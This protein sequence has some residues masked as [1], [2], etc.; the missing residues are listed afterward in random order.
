VEAVGLGYLRLGQPLVTLSGGEAQ[1]LKLARALVSAKEGTLL[2]LDEPTVGLHPG[3]VETL[4]EALEQLVERG[5]SVVVVEHDMTVAA[6][7]DWVIDLDPGAGDDG[8]TVVAAGPPAK[9]ASSKSRT[10]PFLAAALAGRPEVSPEA[11]AEPRAS[12][13]SGAGDEVVVRGAREHNLTDLD[14]D[15]P[16]S[17]LT[18]VT[19]PS[20]SGKSTLAF[21]V[22]HAEG[23]RRYLESL[24]TFVRQYL[25]QL[26]RPEVDRVDGVPPSVALEPRS[27]RSGGSTVGTLTE[28]SHYLRLL[29][30]RVGTQHCPD[31][32]VP[33]QAR[34]RT[35]IHADVRKTVGRRGTASLLARVVQNRKGT[36]KDLIVRAARRGIDRVRVDGVMHPTD[37]PP[38]LDRYSEHDVDLEVAVVRGGA[39][40]EAALDEALSVGKGAVRVL[41]GEQETVLSLTRTCPDCGR[42]FGELDPTMFSFHTRKGAC[43]DCE[44]AGTAV[45]LDEDAVFQ[46]GTPLGEGGLRLL[47]VK[48]TRAKL[49]RRLTRAGVPLDRTLAKLTA[50]QRRVLLDGKRPWSGLLEET[51]ALAD[52]GEHEAIDMLRDVACPSCD[53][54]RLSE[55]PSHVVLSGEGT[56]GLTLPALLALP[57]SWALDWLS[58]LD[59]PDRLKA[60]GE[61]LRVE[62]ARRLAFL[63]DTGVGYLTLGRP[64]ETLS[65][66][67]TQRVRLAAQLGSGLTGV[68]Y[69]LDEPTIGL[70][71]RD[72]GQLLGTL[73]RLAEQGCM[74]LVVEHDEQ[75]IR[76]ADHV[77]DL[78]PGGGSRGGRIVAR[79]TP[80]EICASDDS[81]TGRALS[82]AVP[83]APERRDLEGV[84]WLEV[85]G[86]AGHNL[87][88]IDVSFPVERLTVV[89]GVSGSG[90]S[91]LVREILWRGVRR[92]LGLIASRPGEHQGIDGVDHLRRAVEVDQSPI[93]RTPR[94]VPATYIKIWDD[95]RK[96]LARTP[97]ARARGF[98]PERFSFNRKGGRC[99][100]CAGQGAT[101]VEMSF[102]PNVTAKCEACG[103]TRFDRATREVTYRGL[104]VDQILALTAEEAKTVFEAFPRVRRAL[105]LLDDL[106]LGYLALGQ[107]SNT[108]SGGEAQRIKLAAELH[109]R[110]RGGT[111]Y[112]LDEPT[113]GL[114]LSDVGRLVAVLQRLV[115][116]GDTVVVIEHHPDVIWAADYVAD[117]GPEG[118]DEGGGLVV[119]GPPE[120][121]VAHETSYTGAALRDLLEKRTA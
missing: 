3:D 82:R 43:P 80:D 29:Y 51:W 66:G 67:E 72:T 118:G 11:L 63:Q 73:G 83:A 104:S 116:R 74:V 20:G 78:G 34:T 79:G 42:G 46:Q 92:Q 95:I 45:A 85:R 71:P 26:P 54:S 47:E 121:V 41:R 107:P 75:T 55:E 98:G 120:L 119:S 48:R 101:K 32:A 18:V 19:G 58:S 70:H 106:G 52:E 13:G 38:E 37:P 22:V 110:K 30:A 17:G 87:R 64:A 8:G 21:D 35:Q 61:P 5:C 62:A 113:T 100:E 117:L 2:V 97:D 50:A 28:V 31:C 68:A 40:L 93:G 7:A 59:L 44:G 94:S 91:T 102:L 112:V 49:K 90:K 76:G 10:A 114:H 111:L 108:L 57:S 69:V 109:G 1:R 23:Q 89:T 24:S 81:P 27:T 65:G 6:R 25:K 60:V 99:E 84:S 77:V 96:L 16:R 4:L 14:V 88:G 15:L 86:A 53:G 56:E 115:D 12:Y 103:G 33:V 9:V 36:H 39:K 105:E